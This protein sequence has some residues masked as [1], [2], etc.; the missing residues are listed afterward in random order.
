MHEPAHG[1]TDTST[2]KMYALELYTA[3]VICV[4]NMNAVVNEKVPWA[5]TCNTPA[6]SPWSAFHASIAFKK[7]E[8]LSF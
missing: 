2:Q 1:I 6:R 4:V 7:L 3:C 5:C 8:G